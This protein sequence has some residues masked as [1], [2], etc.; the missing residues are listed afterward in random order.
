MSRS[1]RGLQDWYETL[2]LESLALIGDFYTEN[3][4]FKDP[5]N[6]VTQRDDIRHI[7]SKMFETLESPRFHFEETVCEG[8]K[9]FIIWHF[10]FGWRGKPMRI[11]GA[12]HL[13]LN[14]DG[15]VEYHRDYWDAAE[16]LYEKLPVLGWML[17]QVKRKLE[18]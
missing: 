15:R 2:S 5:F 7:F 8:R 11:R 3:A 17:R 10:D 12:S 13:R 4:R 16:E 1:L 9:A 18:A 14:E 6:E